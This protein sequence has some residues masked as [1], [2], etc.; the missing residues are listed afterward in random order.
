MQN[1]RSEA[2]P[3]FMNSFAEYGLNIRKRF[4]TSN[5]YF[6]LPLGNLTA[7]LFI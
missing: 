3:S 1:F 7:G 5:P 6:F 2:A 4:S